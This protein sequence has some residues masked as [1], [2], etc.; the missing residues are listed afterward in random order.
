MGFG[1][2]LDLRFGPGLSDCGRRAGAKSIESAEPNPLEEV[3]MERS[4]Q[5]PRPAPQDA[6]SLFQR[7]A[8]KT[9][10]DDLKLGE[11]QRDVLRSILLR[12]RGP[13]DAID[14]RAAS[15]STSKPSGITALVTGSDRAA[16]ENAAAALATE[17]DVELYRVDLGQVVSK[18]IGE[19]EK[20]LDRVFSAAEK[21]GAVLLFDEADALFGERT[22]VKDAHDR[23]ANI[24][25]GYLV[26]RLE[27]FS[28]VAV[29]AT[30]TRSNIDPAFLRRIRY[31][32]EL[33]NV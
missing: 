29:L 25:V 6:Q 31:D 5:T 28:G 33:P 24:E 14:G 10:L 27:S 8:S 22:D 12:A 18:Y 4:K 19:T 13:A 7:R 21:A 3:V 1:T 17:L 11:P 16:R 2:K 30:N 26:E 15:P 23:Y 32:V 20:N 9:R